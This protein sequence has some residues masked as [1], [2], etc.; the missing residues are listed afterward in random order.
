[1]SR[2][3]GHPVCYEGA[4]ADRCA[5]A[6]A[7]AGPGD[8]LV[9]SDGGPNWMGWFRVPRPAPLELPCR[10]GA[11]VLDDATP[12]ALRYHFLPEG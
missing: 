12:D 6:E 8:L 11:Y 9:P 4:V 1:M 5:E 10:G 2:R 7:G 3:R